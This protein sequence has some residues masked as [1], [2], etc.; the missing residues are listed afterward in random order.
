MGQTDFFGLGEEEG[1]QMDIVYD[2]RSTLFT[3]APIRPPPHPVLVDIPQPVPGQPES[4]FFAKTFGDRATFSVE[5]TPNQ[6][7]HVVELDNL[8]QYT[9]AQGLLLVENRSLRTFL[10]MAFS[11]YPV[12]E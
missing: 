2:Q 3:S 12:N 4:Y 1:L 5:I 7:S 8:T 9:N 11:Q 6:E 10:E